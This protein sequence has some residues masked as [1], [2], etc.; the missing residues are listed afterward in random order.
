VITL[1][2]VNQ[3]VSLAFVTVRGLRL[4]LLNMSTVPPKMAFLTASENQKTVNATGPHR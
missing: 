2:I 3:L 1:Q 4:P